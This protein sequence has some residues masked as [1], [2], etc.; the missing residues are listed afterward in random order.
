M[1]SGEP[2]FNLEELQILF[3]PPLSHL[4]ITFGSRPKEAIV[5]GSADAPDASLRWSIS[6]YFF[7]TL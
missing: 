3:V 1:I 4:T 2:T 7:G 5:S 6:G